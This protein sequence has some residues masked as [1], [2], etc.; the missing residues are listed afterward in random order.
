MVMIENR[1]LPDYYVSVIY[2][3]LL[4]IYTITSA[5][6]IVLFLLIYNFE[7]VADCIG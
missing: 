1:L 6:L 2:P 5:A 4:F 7:K 3:F